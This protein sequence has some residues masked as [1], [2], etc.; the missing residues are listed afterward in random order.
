MKV[1]PNDYDEFED[2]FD[3]FKEFSKR[4]RFTKGRTRNKSQ[5]D[6]QA[7]RRESSKER[8]RTLEEQQDNL[9]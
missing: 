3:S 8:Q 6:I 7:K 1:H 5:E 9:R 2:S 4:P